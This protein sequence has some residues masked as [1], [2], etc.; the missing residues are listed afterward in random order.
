MKSYANWGPE[1]AD[2]TWQRIRALPLALRPNT[3][4]SGRA[5]TLAKWDALLADGKRIAAVGN[6]D[7]AHAHQAGPY[8]ARF[9]R[10]EYCFRAVNTHLLDEPLS[11]DVADDK[12]R[13][14]AAIGRGRVGRLRSAHPT[15][16]FVFTARGLDKGTMG[17]TVR[18]EIGATL[19]A[20]APALC[21]LRL[22]RLVR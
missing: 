14:L 11:G 8:C 19:Q 16:G 9:T 12:R 13:I 4:S 6:S 21:T 5:E 10:Y 15:N 1:I 2:T 18:R 22:I 3:P 20:V 17:D 7:A